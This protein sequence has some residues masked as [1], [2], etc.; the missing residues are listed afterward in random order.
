MSLVIEKWRPGSPCATPV[1]EFPSVTPSYGHRPVC[2]RGKHSEWTLQFSCPRSPKIPHPQDLRGRWDSR[3]SW[4]PIWSGRKEAPRPRHWSELQRRQCA[5]CFLFLCF[6]SFFLL[7]HLEQN[8]CISSGGAAI[9]PTQGL[10]VKK[11]DFG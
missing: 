3:I 7:A 2:S 4:I 6:L 1:L 11:K 8:H 9:I 10:H 5:R